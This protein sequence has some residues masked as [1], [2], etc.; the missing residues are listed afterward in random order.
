M[1]PQSKTLLAR[2]L[3]GLSAGLIIAPAFA[4]PG[5]HHLSASFSAGFAHPFQGWD[6]LLAMLAVGVWGAQQSRAAALTWPLAFALMMAL[7][8]V[9][10]VVGFTLPMAETGIALSVV[11]LG[12]LI[13]FAV[14]I[15]VWGGAVLVSLFT[16]MHGFAHGVEMPQGEMPMMYIA[17][18]LSATALLHLTGLISALFAQ[19]RTVS[20]VI[21]A[22]GMSVAVSGACLLAT[23]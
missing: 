4:H 15:P 21:R 19:N 23:I 13:A 20:N 14:R 11:L 3:I 22:A 7:G 9:V 17:G 2:I 8:A 16:T 10:G 12:V 1:A 18:I 6:H 5:A